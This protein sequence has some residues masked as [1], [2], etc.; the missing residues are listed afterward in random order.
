MNLTISQSSQEAL[1][2][3]KHEL[4]MGFTALQRVPE[5]PSLQV[6]LLLNPFSFLGAT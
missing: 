1:G 4:L 6:S 3:N 5:T 2:V